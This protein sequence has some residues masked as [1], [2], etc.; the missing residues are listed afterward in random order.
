MR[1]ASRAT[2]SS[3]RLLPV[4]I[5][6]VGLGA[7]GGGGGSSSP[8]VADAPVSPP[9]AGNPAPASSAFPAGLSLASPTE[10]DSEPV[11]QASA[12]PLLDRLFR[13]LASV[14]I[15]PEAHAQATPTSAFSARSQRIDA[16]L[17]GAVPVIGTLVKPE[18]LVQ[19]DRDAPCY[20]PSLKYSTGHPNR[21]TEPAGELPPGDLGIWTA[22]DAS[23]GDAC[24][25]AQ[26]NA[27]MSGAA[28]RGTQALRMLAVLARQAATSAGGLPAA[29]APA[30]DLTAGLPAI[31]ALVFRKA[32]IAQTVAGTY[33]Y[34]IQAELTHPASGRLHRI[35]MMLTHT[36]TTPSE[37]FDGLL[38]YAIT[39]RFTGGNCPASPGGSEHDVTWV[40]TLKYAKTSSTALDLSHRTGMYCGA[41]S[42]G[43]SLATDR[44]ATYAGDGQL[45]PSSKLGGGTGK[46]WGNNFSRFAAS[47]NPSTEA[48]RYVYVWQAGPNDNHGRT[49]Q[50]TLQQNLAGKMAV[51]HFGFGADIASASSAGQIQGMFCNWAGPGHG[52]KGAGAYAPFAQRQ[53]MTLG[54]QWVPSASQILY[55]PTNACTDGTSSAAWLDRNDDGVIDGA[56]TP[57]TVTGTEAGFLIGKGASPDIPSAIGFTVPSLY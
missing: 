23:S 19:I 10:V 56:D 46:G 44:G 42:T 31:P 34:E 32:T 29:G 17:N 57:V 26:L 15:L 52:P 35:D 41:G 21:S 51:A 25:A 28:Q 11:T 7:C 50:V 20:G 33:A 54:T 6:I 30:L 49:L 5:A 4:A 18:R 9:V 53:A 48:G 27:R 22:T 36:T 38:K 39:G 37:V 3:L 16:L 24:A 14:K 55:A 45:D 1:A 8:P 43:G 40:G 47:F 12:A 2:T 13:A